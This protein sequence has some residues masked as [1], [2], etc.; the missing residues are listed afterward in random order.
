M[1]AHTFKDVQRV[2][3]GVQ[4]SGVCISLP[5]L[6]LL[7]HVSFTEDLH[8]IDMTS[9]L[10]LHQTNLEAITQCSNQPDRG[11]LKTVMPDLVLQKNLHAFQ[12]IDGG[13]ELSHLKRTLSHS[14][15]RSVTV[16]SVLLLEYTEEK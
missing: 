13:S 6:F 14:Q 2:Q 12:L 16:G 5:H 1:E 7:Q 9:V 10:L 3:Q 15:N 4:Y 11:L 8:G